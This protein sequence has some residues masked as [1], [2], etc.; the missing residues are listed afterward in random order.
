MPPKRGSEDTRGAKAKEAKAKADAEKKSRDDAKK[1]AEED[2]DWA[3]GGN[4]RA[5]KK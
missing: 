5:L 4:A 2:A 3:A 1:Q